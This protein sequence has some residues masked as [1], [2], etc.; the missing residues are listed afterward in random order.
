MIVHCRNPSLSTCRTEPRIPQWVLY[1]NVLQSANFYRSGKKLAVP[2]ESVSSKHMDTQNEDE[3]L[4]ISMSISNNRLLCSFWDAP[5]KGHATGQ[6]WEVDEPSLIE[7][8][9][10]LRAT[11]GAV[12][13]Q[14]P[15]GRA[16]AARAG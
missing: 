3:H 14:M 7:N 12:A 6:H 9:G 2:A 11:H 15:H 4:N 16:G 1:C 8:A 5:R 13:F 10:E